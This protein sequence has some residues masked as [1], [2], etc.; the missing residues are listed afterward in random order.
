M[1]RPSAG[2]V[3]LTCEGLQPLEL[4]IYRRRNETR[5]HNAVLRRNHI[6]PVSRHRPAPGRL[7][8]NGGHDPCFKLDFLPKLKTVCDVIGVLLN[9][10][11]RRVALGPFPVLLQLFRE[12]IGVFDTLNID[13]R[14]GVAVP[15]PRT[16]YPVASLEALD[17]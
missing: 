12:G 16:P 10:R 3:L 1:L 14:A 15:V 17:R 8:E 5:G 4:W 2:H 9:F 7:I 13:T 6:P 11:L